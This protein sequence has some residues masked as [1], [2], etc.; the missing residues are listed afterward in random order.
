MTQFQSFIFTFFFPFL[1][2]KQ[3]N[4]THTQ[5]RVLISKYFT[6]EM[7]FRFLRISIVIVFFFLCLIIVFAVDKETPLL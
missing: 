1:T 5:I 4:I 7:L 2:N 3:H 6:N